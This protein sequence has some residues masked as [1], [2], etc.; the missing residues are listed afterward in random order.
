[1]IEFPKRYLGDSVYVQLEPSGQLK[2]TT[3]DGV[4]TTNTIYLEGEVYLELVRYVKEMGETI[5]AASAAGP[6]ASER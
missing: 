3:E 6:P 4:G 2:L 5:A 1:M